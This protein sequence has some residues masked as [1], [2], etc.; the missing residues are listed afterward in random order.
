MKPKYRRA[1]LKIGGEVFSGRKKTIDGKSLGFIA[2]EIEDALQLGTT[3]G[4]VVGGGN[5]F[6]GAS[7]SALGIDRVTG[8]YMGMLGTMINALV[9]G[10]CLEQRGIPAKVMSAID[11]NPIAERYVKNRAICCINQG[12]VLIFA[13]GTGNPYFTTDTAASLRTIEIEAE[14]LIKG[15]KVDGVYEE[16]PITSPGAKRFEELSYLDYLDR[17]LEV[18]DS[19]AISFCMDHQLPVIVYNI[20]ERG[21]LRRVLLGEEVGTLI[22]RQV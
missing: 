4:I 18:M 16:D 14:L 10:D 20:Y 21:N 9:L 8:D 22:S 1:L 15:T 12:Q 17:G 13:C 19:T 7:A 2:G 11:M 5:I 6:R 3:L